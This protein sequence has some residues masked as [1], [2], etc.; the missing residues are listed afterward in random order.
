MYNNKCM[1]YN[2]HIYIL[3]ICL[4]NELFE[5]ERSQHPQN[6]DLEIKHC[7]KSKYQRKTENVFIIKLP[8]DSERE[9]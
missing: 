4:C 1:V 6:I 9:C 3:Y 8:F 2:T 7:E 5:L